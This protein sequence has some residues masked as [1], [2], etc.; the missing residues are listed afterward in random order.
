MS[1]GRQYCQLSTT[2][3]EYLRGVSTVGER[4]CGDSSSTVRDSMVYSYIRNT[5]PYRLQAYDP[6]HFS[7]QTCFVCWW[8]STSTW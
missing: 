4:Y 8:A 6:I 1:L 5:V 7:E 3:T 2:Y